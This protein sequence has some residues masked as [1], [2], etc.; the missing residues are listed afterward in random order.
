MAIEY[1]PLIFNGLTAAFAMMT[2]FKS[3]QFTREVSDL[4]KENDSLAKKNHELAEDKEDPL[5]YDGGVY[6]NAQGEMFCPNCYDGECKKR[7][8]LGK[9]Y[10]DADND[11][12]SCPRCKTSHHKKLPPEER[13]KAFK[14]LFGRG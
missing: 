12:Y 11:Y 8:H 14:W 5:T 6:V 2:A 4:K 13:E 1:I 10:G 7:M 9:K 3:Y